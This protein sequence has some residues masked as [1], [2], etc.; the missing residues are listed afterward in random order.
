MNTCI[1]GQAAWFLQSAP[2]L[3]GRLTGSGLLCRACAFATPGYRACIRTEI[4]GPGFRAAPWTADTSTPEPSL[5]PSL[6]APEQEQYR[7]IFEGSL[8]G[9]FLWDEHLRIVDVNPAGLALYGYR[10]EDIVGRTFPRSMPEAYV[11][12]RDP[13][14]A[15]LRTL[16][17][18]LLERHEAAEP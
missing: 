3:L 5:A 12:E 1:R 10:R 4:P 17:G 15:A 8:D 13:L 14:A 2:L 11:L 6:P 16:P 18:E 7:A 9:L